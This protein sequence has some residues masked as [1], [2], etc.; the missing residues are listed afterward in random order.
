[1]TRY[2]LNSAVIPAGAAGTWRYMVVDPS[3]ARLWL[4]VGP[5][6]SRIG[7]PENARLLQ[8][9]AGVPVAVDRSEHAMRPGDQALV[10]RLRYRVEGLKGGLKVDLADFEFGILDYLRSN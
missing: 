4:L 1:M 8:D 6:V 7:Y 9:L 10:M 3:F 5:F 2:L